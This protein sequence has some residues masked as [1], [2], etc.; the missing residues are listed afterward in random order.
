[1]TL[2]DWSLSAVPAQTPV[3]QF[4]W[5][6]TEFLRLIDIQRLGIPVAVAAVA[7]A[8]GIGAAHAL[9]PGHGKAI[10]A[11]YLV[12]TNGRLRDAVALGGLVAA[13]HSASVVVLGTVLYLSARTSASL[14]ALMPVLS[15]AA[16]LLVLTVG[17]GLLRHQL[18]LRRARGTEDIAHQHSESDAHHDGRSHVDAYAHRHTATF[19]RKSPAHT[20]P[21]RASPLSRPGV[22]LLG[23]SGGLLPSPSAFL[24]LTTALFIGRP[25]YGLMLVL[26]FSI[27]LAASLTLVGVAAVHGRELLER[28]VPHNSP[29]ARLLAALPFISAIIVL[30]GG[31]LLTASAA[32]RL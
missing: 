1:M 11:A 16:G 9:A 5:F 29:L 20:L 26:A 19:V 7:I 18:L 8:I 6:E 27:G 21:P 31:I 22:M 12:G 23:M 24:V 15:T 25:A 30:A 14:T 3:D 10:I 28:R 4:G 13:L 2:S 17:I 32:M